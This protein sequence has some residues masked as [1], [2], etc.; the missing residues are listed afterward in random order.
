MAM[1]SRI[2]SHSPDR[3]PVLIPSR[4]PAVERSWQGEPPAMMSTGSTSAQSM[5]VMSPRFGASGNRWASILRAPLSMSDTHA[6][7]ASK[8][9]STA[10][11]RPPFNSLKTGFQCGAFQT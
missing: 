6:V 1:A 8:K 7:V 5:R 3:V 10:R 4:F 9:V 11:S 2:D